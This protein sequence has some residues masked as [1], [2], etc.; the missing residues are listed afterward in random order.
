M[1]GFFENSVFFGVWISLLFYGAG[2]LLKKKL[3]M[4]IFNP[5]LIAILLTICF[6]STLTAPFTRKGQDTFPFCLRRLPYAW[7]SL[8][9]NRWNC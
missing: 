7:L 1:N 4:A 6:V 5:L 8:C 2:C 3:K 9:M